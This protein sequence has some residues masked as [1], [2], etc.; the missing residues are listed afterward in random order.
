MTILE[1]I[2]NLVMSLGLDLTKGAG[3]T[4]K[5]RLVSAF[6]KTTSGTQTIP[7]IFSSVG[8]SF[9]SASSDAK[10]DQES[11]LLSIIAQIFQIGNNLAQ[12]AKQEEK[13]A[14]AP[15][16]ADT[17]EEAQALKQL[18]ILGLAVPQIA[19]EAPSAP[20]TKTQRAT[21]NAMTKSEQ[22]D[23]ILQLLSMPR[24]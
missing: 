2:E 20:S 18:K 24:G 19:P 13:K 23:L 17:Q 10:D 15:L 7:Q 11:A 1:M 5:N 12:R 14:K 21:L 22:S 6:D 8:S 16:W 9:A 4:I 3:K